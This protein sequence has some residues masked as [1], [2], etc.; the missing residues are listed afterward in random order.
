MGVNERS[1]QRDIDYIRCFM[2]SEIG[3][4]G[5]INDVIYDQ[6]SKGI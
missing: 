1:I 6:K 5:I 4:T 3:R 2:E